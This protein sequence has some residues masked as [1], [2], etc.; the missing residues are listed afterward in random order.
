M[1]DVLVVY[2]SRTGYTR[3]VAERIAREIG[4]D[5]EPIREPKPR[6]GIFGYWRSARE[7][8]RKVVA[9]ILP[10]TKLA[11]S[12]RLIVLGTPVWASHLSSPMRAYIAAQG[13]SFPRVA[14][15]CTQGGSGAQKVL[16]E[17]RALCGRSPDATM[18]VNDRDVDSGAAG[19][20][21]EQFLRELEPAAAA[22]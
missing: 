10:P 1:S 8:L 12:Y 16:E 6:T 5:L 21:V 9:E 3:R 11:R 7:S 14:F 13:R 2:F 19:R 22:A 4:A 20:K 15:F 18:I 17:M